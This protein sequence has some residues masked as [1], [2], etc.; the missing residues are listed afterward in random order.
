M[1]GGFR[2]LLL[3]FAVI[4]IPRSLKADSKP[5]Q[6]A[7]TFKLIK[8]LKLVGSEKLDYTVT[9]QDGKRIKTAV[10]ESKPFC[11]V[12]F[13][14]DTVISNHGNVGP[15]SMTP[16]S[17]S[18]GTPDGIRVL[19]GVAKT[20]GFVSVQFSASKGQAF[21]DKDSFSVSCSLISE[22]ATKAS[23]FTFDQISK[24]LG[25]TFEV[26]GAAESK[27]DVAQDENK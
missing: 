13:N 5:A 14:S 16:A 2:V 11:Q 24:I 15:L 10:D 1:N 23:L 18:P 12:F 3:I 22:D 8:P 25:S 9:F 27:R 17:G 19:P 20:T 26:I 7:V 4:L 21:P 6:G